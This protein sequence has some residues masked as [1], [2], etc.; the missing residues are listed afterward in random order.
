MQT[1]TVSPDIPV[2]AL[3]TGTVGA[4]IAPY[5]AGASQ[6]SHPTSHRAHGHTDFRSRGYSEEVAAMSMFAAGRE[7]ATADELGP[8]FD[9]VLSSGVFGTSVGVHGIAK[10]RSSIGSYAA[11]RISHP[12]GPVKPP[13]AGIVPSNA[14][15]ATVSQLPTPVAGKP[16][17]AET[18][19]LQQL[20][21]L[22]VNSITPLQALL[23]LSQLQ[24]ALK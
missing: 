15:S 18:A 11:S 16:T 17:S 8:E 13:A 14:S 12:A 23:V 22:D 19:V 21:A 1:A 9:A 2:G 20:R 5:T 6:Y 24:A 3:E 7:S 4:S 10:G